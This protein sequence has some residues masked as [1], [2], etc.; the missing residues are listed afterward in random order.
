[1]QQVHDSS[2]YRVDES[3]MLALA[4]HISTIQPTHITQKILYNTVL[5]ESAVSSKDRYSSSF[6]SDSEIINSV[7]TLALTETPRSYHN[8]YTEMANTVK[9]KHS[10]KLLISGR[11]TRAYQELLKG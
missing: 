10:Y 1:M 4:S 9:R 6:L 8:R 5:T 7:S 11:C 3:Y 2:R